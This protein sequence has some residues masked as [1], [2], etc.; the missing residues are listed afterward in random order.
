[1]LI[2]PPDMAQLLFVTLFPPLVSHKP[3]YA[4]EIK[5]LFLASGFAQDGLLAGT[6]FPNQ[7][8]SIHLKPHVPPTGC[9]LSDFP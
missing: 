7:T 1:M 5:L 3:T 2:G 9:I 8:P 4:S 6:S